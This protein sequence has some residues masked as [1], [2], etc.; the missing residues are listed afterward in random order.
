MNPS[1]KREHIAYSGPDSIDIVPQ[2]VGSL[3]FNRGRMPLTRDEFE[4]MV[5]ELRLG[6]EGVSDEDIEEYRRVVDRMWILLPSGEYDEDKARRLA[7]SELT[8]RE[9]MEMVGH[10]DLNRG[11]RR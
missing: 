3:P 9:L 5:A 1:S 2:A 4:A 8:D 11:E 6:Y 7:T 10:P